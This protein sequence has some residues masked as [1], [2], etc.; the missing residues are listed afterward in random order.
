MLFPFT[1]VSGIVGI[2]DITEGSVIWR[3]LFAEFLGTFL[4]VLLGCG[5][6]IAGWPDYSPTMLHISLTFGL[7]VATL[8]QVSQLK[9]PGR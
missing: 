1:D 3:Q 6:T 4:L 2:K 8:V 7:A 9:L 5:S